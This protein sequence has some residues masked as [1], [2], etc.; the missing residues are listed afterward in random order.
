MHNISNLVTF[1]KRLIVERENKEIES[2][3]LFPDW[4]TVLD[5]NYSN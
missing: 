1:F 5:G 3:K 4:T 2:E